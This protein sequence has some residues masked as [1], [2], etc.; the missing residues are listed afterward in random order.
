MN[1]LEHVHECVGYWTDLGLYQVLPDMP[2]VRCKD[3]V[4][5]YEH[6]DARGCWLLCDLQLYDKVKPEDFCSRGEKKES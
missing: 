6:H 5:A 2:I 4:Y 1:E 3:C